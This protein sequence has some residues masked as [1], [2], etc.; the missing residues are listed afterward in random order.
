[1]WLSYVDQGDRYADPPGWGVPG[2]Y[3][4]WHDGVKIIQQVFDSQLANWYPAV[5]KAR[6][7]R[8]CI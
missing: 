2:F 7:T 5:A 4:T 8:R 6:R 1:M 3:E